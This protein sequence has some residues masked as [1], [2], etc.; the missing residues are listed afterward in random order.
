MTIAGYVSTKDCKPVAKA[1]VGLWHADE[2]GTYD[3][4]AYRLRGHQFTGAEGRWWFD[5][6]VAG[7]YPGRTRRWRHRRAQGE[8]AVK[9]KLGISEFVRNVTGIIGHIE[10]ALVPALEGKRVPK[11]QL[12]D[13]I[14]RLARLARFQLENVALFVK[15]NPGNSAASQV[16]G[17]PEGSKWREM[18]ELLWVLGGRDSWP[19]EYLATWLSAVA[20]PLLAW[21]I[22]SGK[23][24]KQNPQP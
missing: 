6:I 8:R 14:E 20:L 4:E 9:A 17:F 19:R 22:D 5:T 11:G 3:N 16:V 15:L 7:L 12:A 10:T 18:A 23:G 1:L 24:A 21:S 13:K 2:T